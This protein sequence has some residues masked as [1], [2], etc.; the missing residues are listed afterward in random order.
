MTSAEREAVSH[1]SP[2]LQVDED[3]TDRYGSAMQGIGDG[4]IKCRLA[5]RSVCVNRSDSTAALN[6]SSSKRNPQDVIIGCA[7]SQ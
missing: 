4:H 5:M 6:A 3:V 1:M 7:W 2:A